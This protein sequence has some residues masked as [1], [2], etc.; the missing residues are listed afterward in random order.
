V[1]TGLASVRYVVE[2]HSME[3]PDFWEHTTRGDT[4]LDVG[5][6]ELSGSRW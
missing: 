2:T 5:P 6:F 4:P 3:L 1:N